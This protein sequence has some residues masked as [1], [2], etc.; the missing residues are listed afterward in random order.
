ML[1]S[2]RPSGNREDIIEALTK[3]KKKG[4]APSER[5]AAAKDDNLESMSVPELKELAEQRGIK[6]KGTG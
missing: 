6:P 4:K 3:I 5:N 2:Q 1:P